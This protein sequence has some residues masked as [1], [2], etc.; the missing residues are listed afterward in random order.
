MQITNQFEHTVRNTE[1]SYQQILN[2]YSPP[3]SHQVV[4][5]T[6]QQE[7]NQKIQA[8]LFGPQ[9]FLS[10]KQHPE[11]EIKNRLLQGVWPLISSS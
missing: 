10:V 11:P 5:T 2:Q 4:S 1:S 6:A 3:V 9:P 7:P 8:L